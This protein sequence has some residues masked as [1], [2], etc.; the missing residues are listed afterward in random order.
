M[1]A[2]FVETNP[3]PIKQAMAWAGLPSGPTRLPLGKLSEASEAVLR[4]A[5]E[6]LGL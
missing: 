5:Y 6:G 4:K 3:A 1:K 2:A